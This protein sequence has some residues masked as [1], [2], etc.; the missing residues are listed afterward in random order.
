M[1]PKAKISLVIPCYNEEAALESFYAELVRQLP[2]DYQFEIILVDD[3]SKDET[4]NCIKKLAE[5]DNR[6]CYISFSRNFGHQNALKAGF[7]HASGDCAICMDA[8]LQHPPQHIK[9]FIEK[10]TEG[11]DIVH[12]IRTDESTIGKRK[13]C[14]SKVFYK[15]LNH[16]SDVEIQSG[17]ADFRLIDRKVL[18]QLK[19]FS[20]NFIFYR[21]LFPWMGFRQ[22]SISY[23]ANERVAGQTKYTFGKMVR[24]AS[25]GLTSFSVKPLRYSI[26]L[27]LMFAFLAFA[28]LI[29]A[30][31]VFL[32]TDWAITGWTSLVVSI[33]FFGGIN[34]IM[35]GVIGEYLGKLFIESK[36]RPNYLV[37]ESNINKR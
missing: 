24:F 20:E 21:G 15:I 10:W 36:R 27:G 26:Y 35:L 34:L 7:D 19:N 17:M 12:S 11:Y 16:F 23:V 37:A 3:G 30:V 6:I 8:D 22:T 9:T 4:L 14:S 32:F 13:K 29:Y 18:D 5:Q 2:D 28:Y 31:L 25:I 1:A 33:M